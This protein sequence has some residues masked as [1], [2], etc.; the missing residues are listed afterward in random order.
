M[1]YNEVMPK[2]KIIGIVKRR[3]WS[4]GYAVCE[5]SRESEGYDLLVDDTFR[6]RIERSSQ[7]VISVGEGEVIAFLT[8]HVS[9]AIVVYVGAPNQNNPTRSPR[10]VFGLPASKS[11]DHVKQKTRK[12]AS[13]KSGKKVAS[14]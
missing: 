2:E 11:K 7:G 10:A 8:D 13:K 9:G 12:E 1:S 3:L 5:R 6:V 4:S 14:A